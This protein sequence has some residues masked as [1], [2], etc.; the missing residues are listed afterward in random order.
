MV[1]SGIDLPSESLMRFLVC[2]VL[3]C[4][5]GMAADAADKLVEKA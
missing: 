3:L 5:G 4:A 1:R 2:A